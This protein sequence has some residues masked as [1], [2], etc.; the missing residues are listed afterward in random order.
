MSPL[1]AARLAVIKVGSALL[2]DETTGAPNIAWLEAFATDLARLRGRGQGVILVS[3]GAVA[4]G[5]ERLGLRDRRLNLAEKQAAASAGQ[6]RLM[7]AW[8]TAL[9]G[10]GLGV[11]QVLLTPDDT[12]VRRRFLNA[13]ATLQTLLACGAIPVVNENDAVAT[14]ELRYGDND[15]LAARVAQMV[16]ADL[17]VLLSDVDGL[18]SGDPRKDPTARHLAAVSRIDATIEA[19]AGGANAE[20]GLGSGGMATKLAAARIAAAAGCRTLIALGRTPSPLAALEAGAR[21]T[22]IDAPSTPAAAY[23]AWI[24]GSLTPR[25]LVVADAG[26]VAALQSGKSL[27]AAGVTAVEGAFGKGDAVVVRGPDGRDVAR[28]LA[29]LDASEVARIRG[30][31]SAEIEPLLGYAPG[32]VIHAD[33]LAWLESRAS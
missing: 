5:R 19:M 33:D 17:L 7:R 3:S 9:E 20:A 12:E 6:S 31:R 1:A 13:R 16:G 22:L 11:A 4:L 32:P 15:R 2:V 27:L 26:A 8:E 28:G 18:Y 21:H 24:A 29:R 14:E 10:V 23:K 25:G 30:R